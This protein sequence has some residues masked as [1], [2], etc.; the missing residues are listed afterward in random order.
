MGN[1]HEKYYNYVVDKLISK[2][3]I[4]HDTKQIVYDFPMTNKIS[5]G[6]YNPPPEPVGPPNSFNEFIKDIY[7]VVDDESEIIWEKFK[8]R[9]LRL[10]KNG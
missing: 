10:I 6:V 2:T 1:K 9:V 4:L 7:G 3:E 5:R 8:R